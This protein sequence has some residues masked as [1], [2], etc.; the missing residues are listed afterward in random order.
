MVLEPFD[1][2]PIGEMSDDEWHARR[3]AVIAE[4]AN[5]EDESAH[6]KGW[7]VVQNSLIEEG[8]DE[9]AALETIQE[10]LRYM[11][12]K[13]MISECDYYYIQ[14]HIGDLME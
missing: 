14:D 7:N 8:Y 4:C 9:N 10:V 12:N 11:L 6:V 1:P 5:E 13:A 2:D 3:I